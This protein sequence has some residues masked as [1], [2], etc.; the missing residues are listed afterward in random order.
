MDTGPASDPFESLMP[1]GL[2]T[3]PPVPTATNLNW[4]AVFRDTN[5]SFKERRVELG[6]KLLTLADRR[7]RLEMAVAT[8][9][10]PMIIQKQTAKMFP[11]PQTPD[12]MPALEKAQIRKE[13]TQHRETIGM[14]ALKLQI[15]DAQRAEQRTKEDLKQL[16]PW[17]QAQL[18]TSA[19]IAHADA[20]P[21]AFKQLKEMMTTYFQL[22][23]PPVSEAEVK[24]ADDFHQLSTTLSFAEAAAEAE[25][26]LANVT[27]R[28]FDKK[29]A[30]VTSEKAREKKKESKEEML[31]TL[32]PEEKMRFIFKEEQAASRRA[33]RKPKPKPKPKG[34][35]KGRATGPKKSG[36][37][38][39]KTPGNS[40]GTNNSSGRRNPS[41]TKKSSGTKKGASGNARRRNPPGVK[42]RG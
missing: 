2:S 26:I 31:A 37:P 5:K 11:F 33:T 25:D 38:K 6:K 32:S 40:P 29:K 18:V 17:T 4:S 30:K 36:N 9:T 22:P 23:F 19:R 34:K 1:K 39:K 24:A 10:L 21:T 42:K 15:G 3:P 12:S 16:Q 28:Y 27:K 13:V 35:G 8:S 7:E 41:G 14:A 20:S